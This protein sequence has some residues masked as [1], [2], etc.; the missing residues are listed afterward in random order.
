MQPIAQPQLTLPAQ[1]PDCLVWFAGDPCDQTLQQYRQAV[2]Q[3]QQQEWQ[4][5]VAD[6]LRKQIAEQQRQIGDQQNQIKTLQLRIESRTVE[7]V[8]NEAR[9]LA[10]LNGIG[11][12][13]GATLA[14][15]VAVAGFRR[16]AR[17]A[18]RQHEQEPTASAE[19]ARS[20]F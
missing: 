14:F 11:A 10:V 2:E 3:R 18:A 16:L 4:A 5:S 7:A 19:P 12:S 20:F 8:Q 15:L 13:I 1:N 6:P 9:H 17:S